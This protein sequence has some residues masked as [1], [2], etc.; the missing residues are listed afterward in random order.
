MLEWLPQETIFF[1]G[2]R[3]DLRLDVL[4][5]ADACYIG[6]EVLC[7]GRTASSERFERGECA[8][9][10]TIHR[11][12]KPIWMERGMVAGADRLLGASAGLGGEPVTGVLVAVGSAL[13]ADLVRECR[14]PKPRAG[15]GAVTLLPRVLVA[16]YLGP[17][18]E[19]ARAYFIDI[20]T[21]LRPALMTREAT[22]PRIWRT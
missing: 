16:R 14:V 7:F 3:A 2:A 8:L 19:A 18:T 20:W 5:A 10:T 11:D 9:S 13:D 15:E 21:V 17:S 1:N 4:L 6:W 22:M 12:G